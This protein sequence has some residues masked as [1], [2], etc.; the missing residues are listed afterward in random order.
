MLTRD[1]NLEN[2]WIKIKK[3]VETNDT[4]NYVPF[5]FDYCRNFVERRHFEKRILL[6]KPRKK[7]IE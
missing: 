4:S 3:V 6:T 5:F 2:I 7:A 1:K